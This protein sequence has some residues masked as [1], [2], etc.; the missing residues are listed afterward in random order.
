MLDELA[1]GDVGKPCVAM[2]EGADVELVD[3]LDELLFE[4]SVDVVVLSPYSKRFFVLADN[5]LDP[6]RGA[7]IWYDYGSRA[8]VEWSD[9]RNG[10]EGR[11]YCG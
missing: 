5:C 10:Q 11:I 6:Q 2:L 7:Y 1:G 3:G 4:S 9:K 8:W